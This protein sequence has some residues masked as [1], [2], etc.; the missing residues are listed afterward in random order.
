M[1]PERTDWRALSEKADLQ[2][3]ADEIRVPLHGDRKQ[4]VRVSEPGDRTIR[5]WSMVARKAE[6]KDLPDAPLR[7]WLRN[8][9]TDLVGFKIDRHG[10]LI[11]EAWVP[12]AG[13]DA[14]EWGLYVRTLARACDR[15]EYVITGRDEE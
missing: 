3:E 1:A 4:T 12:L 7:A 6:V 14:E 5:L 9:I 2:V 11:G 10:C 13:L 8:R 15:F